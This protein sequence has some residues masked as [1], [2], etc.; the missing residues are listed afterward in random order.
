M[1]TTQPK[2]PEK[3]EAYLCYN[4]RC[5][6]AIEFYRRTLGAHVLLMMRYKDSPQ[7]PPPGMCPPGSEDKIMHASV[8]IGE[9]RLIMSD[10]RCTGKTDFQGFSLSLAMPTAAEAERIFT[11]LAEG[12]Q[13]F[14]PLTKTFYSPCFGMVSDKFG[15]S[16]MV[17]VPT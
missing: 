12:G 9:T 16:W 11:A 3:V 4:G 10:G 5:A 13:V 8:V 2:P 15:I 7:P 6:E 1:T 17:I 14:M